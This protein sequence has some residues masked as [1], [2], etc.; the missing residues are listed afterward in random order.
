MYQ[1]WV[2]G[3]NEFQT[4]VLILAPQGF[5]D[6]PWASYSTSLSFKF[7]ARNGIIIL[8]SGSCL[9]GVTEIMH[10]ES[11]EQCLLLRSEMF[12]G[13]VFLSFFLP[14]S[15]LPFPFPPVFPFFSFFLS[16][17]Q[18]SLS[19]TQA[20]VQW[21]NLDSQ[22]P[23]PLGLKQFSC[24]RL[25]SSWDYRCVPP[26]LPNF[27]IFSRDGVSP[28][29]PDWSR[30]PEL[31]HST[32]F[33]LPKCCDYGVSHCTQPWVTLVSSTLPLT[34]SLIIPW[35]GSKQGLRELFT[36]RFLPFIVFHWR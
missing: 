28:C 20:G 34:V 30:T 4:W 31:K 13:V 16:V 6:K 22:Q 1:L 19:V 14:S 35:G 18:E 24:L 5:A 17:F 11:L 36:L 23:P 21:R 3:R 33:S 29:W 9:W 26:Y 7:L 27:Y 10:D 12:G 8:I 2:Q 15:S 25:L 32:W